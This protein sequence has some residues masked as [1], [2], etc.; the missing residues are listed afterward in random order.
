[1]FLFR[2]GSSVIY[3]PSFC[4]L[5]ESDGTLQSPVWT[6]LF[7]E[8]LYRSLLLYF[9]VRF[10]PASQ[11]HAVASGECFTVGSLVGEDVGVRADLICSD[12]QFPWCDYFHRC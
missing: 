7:E 11:P 2:F 10:F 4:I 5:L 6:D 8:S 1:M 12:C 3:G 9:Y